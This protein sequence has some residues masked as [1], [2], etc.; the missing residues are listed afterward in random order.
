LPTASCSGREVK[1]VPDGLWVEG[2][3]IV[4]SILWCGI[5]L[6]CL[7]WLRRPIENSLLPRMSKFKAFGVEAEFIKEVLDQEAAKSAPVGDEK[8][9]SSVVRRSERIADLA[10]G[11]KNYETRGGAGSKRGRGRVRHCADKS[12]EPT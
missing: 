12:A 6:F 4:P 8:S 10:A 2:I 1:L 5:A 11:A 3:K 7:I 9:R